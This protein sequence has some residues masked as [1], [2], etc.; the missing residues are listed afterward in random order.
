[1]GRGGCSPHGRDRRTSRPARHRT[2]RSAKA[3]AGVAPSPSRLSVRMPVRPIA[4]HSAPPGHDRP[5]ACATAP[6]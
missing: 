4:Q 2:R 1:V 6:S 5:P 3:P